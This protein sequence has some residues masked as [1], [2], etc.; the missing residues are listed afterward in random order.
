MWCSAVFVLQKWSEIKNRLGLPEIAQNITINL[1]E[2]FQLILHSRLKSVDPYRMQLA[3][4][5]FIF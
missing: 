1:H 2:F 5:Y 3:G 4:W